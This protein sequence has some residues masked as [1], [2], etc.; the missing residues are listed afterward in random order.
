MTTTELEII[1]D[2]ANEEAAGP[3][4]RAQHAQ[5]LDDLVVMAVAEHAHSAEVDALRAGAAAMRVPDYLRYW[6]LCPKHQ[7]EVW[8]SDGTCPICEGHEAVIERDQYQAAWHDAEKRLKA[9]IQAGRCADTSLCQESTIV[10]VDGGA[11]CLR[12]G[13]WE[14]ARHRPPATG[15]GQ[16]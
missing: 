16:Y 2:Q 11:Y 13:L 6:Y 4:D 14:G 12:C 5:I 10:G 1:M 3:S 15:K 8:E 7:P 9:L